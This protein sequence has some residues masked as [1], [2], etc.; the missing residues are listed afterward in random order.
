MIPDRIQFYIGGA[1]TAPVSPARLSVENP[2]TEQAIALIA[3]GM[4]ADID[5]AVASA[6]AAF[7]DWAATRPAERRA[8][9]ER[10]LE[11]TRARQ[12]DLARTIT[13]EM[14]APATMA[15]E[16]QAAVGVSHLEGFLA[17]FDEI[18]W[19]ERLPNGTVIRREPIGV[20]GLITPWN[21]PINQIALKVLPAIATGCTCVLKP[22]ELTPLSA[23]LYMEI[24]DEAGVP[25]GVVNLVNGSGPVA[26]AA[27]SRHPDVDMMSFTGSTRGGTAVS[28]DAAATVKRVTLELGGKSPN[29]VFADCGADLKARVAA[30][31]AEC[32]LNSGQSCDAPTRMLVERSVYDT[33]CE[34]AARVADETIVGDPTVEGDRMGP[35]V[36]AAQWSRVQGYID[37]ARTEGARLIAGGP[38]RPEGVNRGHF[39]RPTVFAD[40]TPDHTIWR[41]EVFGPV[42]AITP[43]ADE[44]E[45]VRLANDTDYGLAAY[46]QTGDP[47]R[48]ARVAAALRAGMVHVNGTPQSPGSP[49]G[50]YSMSGTGREGGL[51]GLEEYLEIKAL[52]MPA[53]WN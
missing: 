12:A 1:W 46:L 37:G 4:D 23:M 44:A 50:G 29:L 42:L 40:V 36:S 51:F 16:E 27:L 41:E 48:A 26:G 3:L 24:L 30:S 53:G 13:A 45:A 32:F 2:A 49:F 34:I 14:G 9:L 52:H 35:L 28:R 17:A 10:V 33:A 25:A 15:F 31:A 43:F 22:S 19:Q 7:P 39:A 47:A 20:C 6:R 5:A 18:P 21:W 8:V 11:V 38:G